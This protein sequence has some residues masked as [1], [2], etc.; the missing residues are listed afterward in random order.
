MNCEI[1]SVKSRY[2]CDLISETKGDLSKLWK[3]VNQASSRNGKSSIPQ[4]IIADGAYHTNPRS[5]SSAL[6]SHFGSI[7]R[8]LP[9]KIPCIARTSLPIDGHSGL[10]Q[11]QEVSESVVNKQLLALKAN[12]AIG[13]DNI[14]AKLLKY[15]AQ[16][17][18]Y[19]I[20]KLINL[21]IRTVKF[22]EIWKCSKVTALL[23]SGDRTNPTNYRPISILPTLSKILKKGNPLSTVRIPWLK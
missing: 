13:L 8:I 18:T 1:K 11:S 16:S 23:K 14:R 10:F 21:L 20:T 5:I 6:N 2:Y 7:G 19:S 15:S 12:K 17:I 4:C 9:E 22:Q 3:A